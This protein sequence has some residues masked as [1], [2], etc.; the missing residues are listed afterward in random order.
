[1]ERQI[2]EVGP[3]SNRGECI[4]RVRNPLWTLARIVCLRAPIEA[5]LIVTRR[6]NL[7]CGYCSEYDNFSAPIPLGILKQRIDALHRLRVLNIALLGGEPLLHPEIDQVVAHANRHAQVSL[8]T[9][10]FLLSDEVIERLNQAGLSNLQVSIDTLVPDPTRYIQKSF[11]SVA[12]KLKRLQRLAQFDFHITLV[13][14]EESKDEFKAT[15]QELKSLG[16][17]VSLNLVHDDTGRVGVSGP[18]FQDLW[19]HHYRKGSPLSFIEYQ[20]GK[21]LLEG[22]RPQWQCRAGARFFY[23]DE[24]G[25]VQFCSAQRGR[26]NK[27]VTEYTSKDIAAHARTSKGCE[28]GC[29]LFCVYRPSQV[30]NAPLSLVRTVWQ[31]LRHNAHSHIRLNSLPSSRRIP[32]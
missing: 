26:L 16:I 5:Q 9:N 19:E 20:Y 21:Q 27:P 32:P 22:K 25:N 18:E 14:C 8:T 31:T 6:C 1:M 24:F 30:D 2:L 12:P 4:V 7:S 10:G 11:R 13:L 15:L 17:A 29:S 3:V 28:A 23:V